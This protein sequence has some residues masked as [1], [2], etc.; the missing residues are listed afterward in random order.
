[1][2][3]IIVGLVRFIA[4]VVFDLICGTVFYFIGWPFVK[5]ATFGRYPI[6]GWLSGS[7]EETYVCCVGI[8]VFAIALM[9][10]LGQFDSLS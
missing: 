7:R 8:V 4:Y 6:K 10:A 2:D 5:L 9:A 3:E 1:M